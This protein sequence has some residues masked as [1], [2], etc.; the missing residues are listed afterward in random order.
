MEERA[1]GYVAAA[2]PHGFTLR[3]AAG[4][5]GAQRRR[6]HLRCGETGKRRI[7]RRVDPDRAHDLLR[8]ERSRVEREIA[9]LARDGPLEG[10]D[11]LEPGD[12]DSETS[13]R[14]S[15]TRVA[16]R[17]FGTSLPPWS[18]PRRASKPARTASRW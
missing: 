3:G 14:T 7:H 13:T 4:W 9:A 5:R 16:S 15:S 18:E 17:T 6:R 11:Q 10:S 8:R 2:R 12:R 1:A